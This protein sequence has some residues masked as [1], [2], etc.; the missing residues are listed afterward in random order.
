MLTL[1]SPLQLKTSRAFTAFRPAGD[2]AA[3]AFYARI[4]GNYEIAALRFTPEDLLLLMTAPPEWQEPGGGMTRISLDDHSSHERSF[5][6]NIVNNVINRILME[7][8]GGFT[9]QDQV[10]VNSV[11][12][13]LG[14]TDVDFFL[15]Q[16][17]ELR[18]D[19][20]SVH[21]LISLYSRGA[22]MVLRRDAAVESEVRK[23]EGDAAS[24]E[25][26]AP[27]LEK[28]FTLHSSVLQRLQTARITALLRQ[29]WQNALD[30]RVFNAWELRISEQTHMANAY[31]MFDLKRQFSNTAAMML[32]T[33]ANVYETGEAAAPRSER[34]VLELASAMLLNL[35]ENVMAARAEWYHTD[36]SIWVDMRRAISG[37]AENTIARFQAYYS[38]RTRH[39]TS[40][41][42]LRQQMRT[43]LRQEE[44][45]L[46]GFVRTLAAPVPMEHVSPSSGEE[47]AEATSLP[48]DGDREAEVT[49]EREWERIQNTLRAQER[50]WAVRQYALRGGAGTILENPALL[51]Q[52]DRDILRLAGNVQTGYGR[53]GA[54]GKD[55]A[56][57]AE[58]D[59]YYPLPLETER[60]EAEGGGAGAPYAKG[61]EETGGWL[62]QA[63]SE[64]G[65][66]PAVRA[67]TGGQ[68][69]DF[70][71]GADPDFEAPPDSRIWSFIE[72]IAALA[73][74]RAASLTPEAAPADLRG[75]PFGE[76]SGEE[77]PEGADAGE[78]APDGFQAERL[79]ARLDE[80]DRR[81]RE[82]AQQLAEQISVMGKPSP[83][84][85]ASSE[86][87][88]A[89]S[90]LAMEDPEK[91]MAQLLHPPS[92]ERAQGGK[93]SEA[94]I[95]PAG[96]DAFGKEAYNLLVQHRQTPTEAPSGATPPE[97][98]FADSLLAMQDPEKAMALLLHPPPD[99]GRAQELPPEAEIALAGADAFSRKAYN[100]FMQYRQTPAAAP[101]AARMENG[102]LPAFNA[103]MA[104]TEAAAREAADR[105][106]IVRELRERA[107]TAGRGAEMAKTVAASPRQN[108][109][110][111]SAAAPRPPAQTVFFMPN[112]AY[113]PEE[114]PWA[115]SAPSPPEAEIRG[116][117]AG[118]RSTKEVI[119]ETEIEQVVR[120]ATA[121][122]AEDISAIV[123]SALA[124]QLSAISSRVYSQV[125]RR[126]SLERARRGK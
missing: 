61:S 14:V 111:R 6:L 74:T 81:N 57:A 58:V 37:A 8:S 121:K 49:R 104:K 41:S 12:R 22:P 75:L 84:A 69:G 42:L 34:Q 102:G 38:E 30:A 59:I 21:N 85:P 13:R 82:A 2:A 99:E 29:H 92:D 67:G 51:R 103:E 93:P 26:E 78:A 35:T 10:Y 19:S 95:A 106:Q 32:H 4:A 45:L 36:Q 114:S 118:E 110:L 96:A 54:D 15:R 98:Q 44:R 64:E 79:K 5:T 113:L 66:A 71:A 124:R 68:G 39:K 46:Q 94:G 18:A 65:D 86:R 101:P 115:V 56:A 23:E 123:N 60:R 109:P 70:A 119:K 33:H 53:D 83:S 28:R 112:Q 31:R 47:S 73:E 50:L 3:D 88:F 63:S 16:V 89:D 24:P 7:G 122:S 9:Y 107:E 17:R 25:A 125:E 77:L 62:R 87:Q 100:L 40:D 20:R 117:R 1:R 48:A 91:A 43:L 27:S 105:T 72:S 97:R 90:L 108:A 11:L 76:A 116:L 126:L 52:F 120:D 55:A 80:Y